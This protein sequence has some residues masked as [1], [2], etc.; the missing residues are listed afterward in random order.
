VSGKEGEASSTGKVSAQESE[1]WVH[2]F[3]GSGRRKQQGLRQPSPSAGSHIMSS[4]RPP[5]LLVLNPH[6]PGLCKYRRGWVGEGRIGEASSTGK[7]QHNLPPFLYPFTTT[8]K[9]FTSPFCLPFS[10]ATPA[11]HHSGSLSAAARPQPAPSHHPPHQHHQPP[12]PPKSNQHH[13]PPSSLPR[14]TPS[15]P[16]KST[17]INTQMPS[18]HL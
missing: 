6:R 16:P 12:A 18:S 13:P 4:S 14:F 3:G 2:V 9:Q 10:P 5:L 7:S 15:N 17:Q 1:Q 8:W 11:G